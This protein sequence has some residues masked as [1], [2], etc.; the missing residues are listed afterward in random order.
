MLCQKDRMQYSPSVSP[1]EE[2]RKAAVVMCVSRLDTCRG[3]NI[4]GCMQK[5]MC[6]NDKASR[7]TGGNWSRFLN[8]VSKHQQVC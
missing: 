5:Y 7:E 3:A 1:H 8:T 6:R 4:Y 2:Q